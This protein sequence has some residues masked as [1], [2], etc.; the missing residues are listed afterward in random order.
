[1]FKCIFNASEVGLKENNLENVP[2]DS[3]TQSKW[4][5]TGGREGLISF[6]STQDTLL[7]ILP[8]LHT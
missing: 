1:M 6:C 4:G 7:C 2:G 8:L 3:V 5:T